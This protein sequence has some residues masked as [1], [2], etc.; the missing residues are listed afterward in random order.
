MGRTG[1]SGSV[2]SIVGTDG[3]L[4]A[5]PINIPSLIVNLPKYIS[6]ENEVPRFIE[7]VD[8]LDSMH[9]SPTQTIECSSSQKTGGSLENSKAAQHSHQ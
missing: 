1:D 2:I 6:V 8:G 5:I 9:W 4:D 7:G 3:W